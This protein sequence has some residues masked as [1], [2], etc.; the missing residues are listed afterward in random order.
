[1]TAGNYL[2]KTK[3]IDPLL[4]AAQAKGKGNDW[5]PTLRMLLAELLKDPN[6]K[7]PTLARKS[8]NKMVSDPNH[9]LTIEQMDAYVHNHYEEPT[10]RE[11]RNLWAVLEPLMQY[12]LVEPK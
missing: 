8:L 6:I 10:E 5:Y 9:R 7:V 4:K 2:D 1:M 3:L 11:L 12:L